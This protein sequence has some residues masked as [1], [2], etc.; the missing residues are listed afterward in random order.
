MIL[1]HNKLVAGEIYFYFYNNNEYQYLFEYSPSKHPKDLDMSAFIRVETQGFSDG[2]GW[3]SY[4][5]AIELREATA[6][7]KAW[8]K[9]C[10]AEK[11]FVSKDK[12][13]V[14]EIINNYEIY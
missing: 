11:R 5:E 8:F 7:E 3:L 1:E 9:K 13:K 4:R 14:D 10:K 12:I 6:L 2:Y